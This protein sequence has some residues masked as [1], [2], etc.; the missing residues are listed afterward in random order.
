L[1]FCEQSSEERAL[2]KDEREREEKETPLEREREETKERRER[3]TLS[4]ERRDNYLYMKKYRKLHAYMY[5]Q[6]TNEGVGR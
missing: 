4:L 1:L 5:Y 2:L 6:P 3:E